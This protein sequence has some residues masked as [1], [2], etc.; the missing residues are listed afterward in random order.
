MRIRGTHPPHH[1]KFWIIYSHFSLYVIP[2]YPRS[3]CIWGP[4]LYKFLHPRIQQP[5]I[6]QD[7]SIY[8]WE[9]STNKWTH[10]VQACVDQGSNVIKLTSQLGAEEHPPSS[11][12]C[13]P[14]LHCDKHSCSL[15]YSYFWLS[16][17]YRASLVVQIVKNLPECRRPFPSMGWEDPLEQGMTTH[18]SIYCLKNPMD[19]GGW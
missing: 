13:P 11:H 17:G 18:P 3:L 15:G 7:Y 2:P 16:L 9:K 19:R 5:R 8:F 6:M 1:Q 14:K 12:S 10:T 4:S